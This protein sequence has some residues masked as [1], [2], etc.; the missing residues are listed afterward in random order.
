MVPPQCMHENWS[1][2]DASRRWGEGDKVVVH[3]LARFL[4]DTHTRHA[5]LYATDM[6]PALLPG[7]SQSISAPFDQRN[8]TT[9]KWP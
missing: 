1:C 3:Y 7:V 2:M 6:T 5:W 9:S 4:Y 8:V